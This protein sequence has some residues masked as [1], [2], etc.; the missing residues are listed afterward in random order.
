MSESV[1]EKL[2]NEDARQIPIIA[3]ILLQLQRELDPHLTYHSAEHTDTVLSDALMLAQAE[4]CSRSEQTLVAI[5]AAYHDAGFLDQSEQNEPFGARRARTAM[6]EARYSTADIC[7]VERMILDTTIEQSS[8]GIV[9]I[10]RHL[11]SPYLL[12]ADVANLGRASFWAQ[13]ELLVR[14]LDVEPKVLARRTISLFEGHR[15]LT[16]TASSMWG[17][18]TKSNLQSLHELV[19]A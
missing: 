5:A 11:L 19:N 16:H 13:F 15:W 14:E 8:A 12:D 7:A 10:A 3:A 1:E 9:H 6:E 18:R 17:E 2:S 4:G